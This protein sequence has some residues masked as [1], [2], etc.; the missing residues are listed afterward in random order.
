M[1]K[2]VGLLIFI[3]LCLSS[4]IVNAFVGVQFGISLVS[5]SEAS[6]SEIVV[7]EGQ[8][9]QDAINSSAANDTIRVMSGIYPEQI[10]VTKPVKLVGEDP[11]TTIIDGENKNQT[12]VTVLASNVEIRGFTIQNAGMDSYGTPTG[13]QIW[14]NVSTTIR[15]NILRNNFLSIWLSESNSCQIIDNII[16]DS[17]IGVLLSESCFNRIVGNNIKNNVIGVRLSSLESENNT[18]FHN[19]FVDNVP[20]QVDPTGMGNNTIWDNGAEGNYWSDYAGGDSDGDGIGDTPYPNEFGW[21]K[22][23]LMEMWSLFRVHRVPWNGQNFNVTTYC[24]STVASFNFSQSEKQ[25]GFNVTGPS[26]VLGFCNVTIPKSLLNASSNGWIV[27]RD[28][29]N[30][31]DD[32]VVGENGTH[33]SIY[34]VFSLGKYNVKIIGTDVIPEFPTPLF[35]AIFMIATMIAVI[36]AKRR[37][38]VDFCAGNSTRL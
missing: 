30:M 2:K 31:T 26:G 38:R 27:F 6:L 3:I 5:K 1:P 33:S 18:L 8:S 25:V 20:L 37:D 11:A 22:Y 15:N 14:S 24:N 10:D 23:P 17:Y 16:T 34:F 21:D 12:I 9:I 32:V 4:T 7:E 28:G 36:L 13:I 19:N 35:F 29:I